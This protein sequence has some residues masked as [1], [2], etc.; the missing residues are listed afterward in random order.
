MLS[1]VGVGDYAVGFSIA[2][3]GQGWYFARPM[4]AA[5]FEDALQTQ[6]WLKAS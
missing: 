2:K 5:A 4:P 3:I 1:P 6:S